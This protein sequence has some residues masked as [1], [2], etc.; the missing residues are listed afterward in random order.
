M[1]DNMK[2]ILIEMLNPIAVNVKFCIYSNH[3]RTLKFEFIIFWKFMM[4][5]IFI[6]FCWTLV[7]FV[8]PLVASISDFG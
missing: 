7:Y 6:N 4:Y 1:T 8:G 2:Q 5:F 3:F